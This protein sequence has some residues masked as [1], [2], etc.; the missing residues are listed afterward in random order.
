MF[1]GASG[2]TF[3]WSGDSVRRA[4]KIVRPNV[5]FGFAIAL[6]CVAAAS[7]LRAVLSSAFGAT[8]FLPFF[9]AVIVATLVAGP[10]SGLAATLMT[11]VTLLFWFH[12]TPG[13]ASPAGQAW[14][15]I[16]FA[17]NGLLTVWLGH[18]VR[19]GESASTLADEAKFRLAAIVESSDDSIVSE[20]LDGVIQ[21]W[22]N[23]AVRL[24]GYSATDMIGRSI[25]RLVPTDL[26][27]EQAAAVERVKRGERVDPFETIRLHRFYGPIRVLVTMSP[28]RTAK[29]KVI[30]AVEIARDVAERVRAE[31]DLRLAKAKNEQSA[32][33]LRAV[34]DAM[35]E[36]VVVADAEGNLLEWNRSALTSHGFSADEALRVPL[37]EAAD[38]F[39]LLDGDR[40]LPLDQWPMSRVLRG[41]TFT[42]AEYG[43]RRLDMPLELV[44][45]Y[46]G[47]PVLDSLGRLMLAVLTLHDITEERSAQTQLRDT[48][49]RLSLALDAAEQ[50]DFVW[51]TQTDTA[52]LSEKAASIFGV[53]PG[54]LVN[55]EAMRQFIDPV[56]RDRTRRAA[57]ASLAAGTDYDMEYRVR[58]PDGRVVWVNARGRYEL[59]ER[60]R[61]RR[62]FGVIADI[63]ARKLAEQQLRDSREW[64]ELAVSIAQ[65]GTFQLDFTQ[66]LVT[67]NDAGRAVYGYTADAPLSFDAVS[68]RIHPADFGNV[69]RQVDGALRSDGPR[70]FDVEHRIVRTDGQVRW[71]RVRGRSLFEESAGH[72][73]RCVG[74]F[75]DVTEQKE[76]EQQREQLLAAE[77]AA[78]ADAEHAGRMKDEFLST[79]SHE[80]RTPLNAILGWS[81]I[82]AGPTTTPEEWTAGLDVIARNA[83][84]QAQII[85]D[86]LDMSRI[87]SGKVRLEVAPTDLAATVLTA[88]DTVRPTATAKGVTLAVSMDHDCGLISGDA[89]RLQQVLW[90]LLVNAIKFTPT[91][92]QVRLTT[93]G[94]ADT[95]Q[96]EVA[97]T[98]EGISAAFLPHVFE[99]FRQSDAS[100][101]RR[102]GGLGLGLAIVKQLSELHG[103]T[104]AAAS[105]GPGQG[106]TFTL[107]L[108]LTPPPR[109]AD[110]AGAMLPDAALAP[111]VA[112]GVLSGLRVLVVDD[113]ADARAMVRRILA[114]RGA[115]VTTAASADEAL[116]LLAAAVPDLIVSD[117]GMPGTDGY[118][119]ISRVRAG[120]FAG[121]ALALTAYA[122]AED[123]ERAMAAGFTSH[124]AKP[125]EPLVLADTVTRLAGR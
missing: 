46:S 78:R 27:A 62:M 41:E 24:F 10:I 87:I 2:G 47:R 9:P 14:S 118:T 111:P 92:G 121:P 17:L 32:G 113:E 35:S 88:V 53:V 18:R 12:F 25:G 36:G 48:A 96:L 108:P 50:G 79:L 115:A 107:T 97:D 16:L 60:G 77:Q 98:G 5:W 58:R 89:S 68:S 56:D 123:R 84:S 114:D 43:V 94:T 95:A 28:L 13:D 85:D 73:T 31:A 112:R 20:G 23:A 54:V 64:L 80:L 100:T 105:P 59:D 61:P 117:V 110:F 22:N 66:S 81:Q 44:I 6:A 39:K 122:R 99:R 49:E 106:T 57:E 109:T 34:I 70:R 74:T 69:S 21:S 7:G 3:G 45:S 51:N 104:V 76:A 40:E 19:F 124:L 29:G 63:T 42:D 93:R 125:V 11:C 120:G 103:G 67:L 33:Q 15:I 83:R 8:R 71:L 65:M 37:S 30:G 72:A 86:L 82:L 91:G 52:V 75:L 1:G 55:R 101:T 38:Y 116:R 26:I 119:L 102:H 4:V 90:N